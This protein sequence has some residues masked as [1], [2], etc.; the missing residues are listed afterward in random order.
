MEI[1]EAEVVCHEQVS[2]DYRLIRL[3]CPSVASAARPGQFVHLRIP[4]CGALT[5]RRPFSIFGAD[6]GS[7]SILYKCVGQGTQIL[8]DVLA[9][10]K[11]SLIGPLGNGFPSKQDDTFPVLVAGGYGV[12]PLLF[13][14]RE[15]KSNGI[16]FVGARTSA[17]ILYVDDFKEIGWEVQVATDDGSAGRSGLV[18]GIL[19]DWLSNDLGKR[20]PEFF[21]C[22]PEGMLRAV[23]DRSM[24]GTWKGWLSLDK[25]MG[26]GVGVCLACVQKVRYEDGSE[27]R[28]RVC[29][30]GPIFEA[31]DIVW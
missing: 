6:E 12:A 1:I 4:G 17:D 2:A 24:A 19:D 13:F 15:T 5:L 29:K 23:G 30:D 9:G 16:L 28:V 14:A 22:G 25:H 31:A 7:I 3:F 26:C 21:A 11:I 20:T 18:T 8:A 27:E 10:R